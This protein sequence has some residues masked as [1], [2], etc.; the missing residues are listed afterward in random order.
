[1]GV[2]DLA[3]DVEPQA[4]TGQVAYGRILGAPEGL[5]NEFTSAGRKADPAIA[6]LHQ[7]AVTLGADVDAY[8]SAGGRVLHRVIDEIRDDLFDATRITH[9]RARLIV[10]LE[11]ER[12]GR[13]QLRS[14]AF[15]GAAHQ[16]AQIDNDRP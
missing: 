12:V 9:Q 8:R 4:H 11:V 6:D 15:D 5:E 14:I 13:R 1:M 16:I 7:T 2:G 10:Q 3:T